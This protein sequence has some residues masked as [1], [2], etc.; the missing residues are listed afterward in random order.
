MPTPIIWAIAQGESRRCKFS[1]SDRNR[2]W[3]MLLRAASL[4]G[5]YVRTL[6][7]TNGPPHMS[8]R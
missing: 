2:L 7:R 5:R 3:T 8:S 6:V 4:E 1:T